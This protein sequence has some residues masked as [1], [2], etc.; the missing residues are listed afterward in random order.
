MFH[1]SPLSARAAGDVKLVKGSA[2]WSG[3]EDRAGKEAFERGW[4]GA[5]AMEVRSTTR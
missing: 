5:G 2:S 1:S 3:A 4:F